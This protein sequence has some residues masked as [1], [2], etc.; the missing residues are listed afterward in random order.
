MDVSGQ[1]AVLVSNA[2]GA[3]PFVIVCD[4]ASNRIPAR[5]GDLGLTPTERLSHIAWDPGALAVSLALQ[6]VLKNL[7]RNLKMVVFGQDQAIEALTASIKMARSGL[8]DP[9]K[10]ID[11]R[12]LLV[13]IAFAEK[14]PL[15]L[16]Q[17][18]EVQFD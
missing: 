10:P 6:D 18:V 7:E 13:K 15:K 17:R 14:A 2:R 4:H 11:T 5:D 3:S 8:A 1:K 12:V 9:S 16:G